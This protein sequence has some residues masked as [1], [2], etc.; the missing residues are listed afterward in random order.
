MKIIIAPDSFKENLT[1]LQ[2]A[3]A[4]EKGIKK[5][6]PDAECIKV[7]MADGGEGTVQ[8]LVDAT[9]GKI[10][11]QNVRDPLGRVVSARYGILGDNKTA[12][13]EMAEASGLPLVEKSSRNPLNTTTYGTGQLII[14]ALDKGAEK[15][16]IGLGG[17]ATVDGGSGLAQALGIKFKLKNNQTVTGYC[18]GGMLHEIDAIDMSEIDERIKRTKFIV[19]CDVDNPL[20]GNRGA[21]RV[22]GPQKG[23]T[24]EMVERLDQNLKHFADVIK[25]DLGVDISEL[26]GAGAAGGVGGALVAFVDAQLQRGVEIVIEMTKLKSYLKRADLVITGEGRIDFQTAFGKTPAGVAQAAKSLGVS[27]LAIGG[28]LADDAAGVFEH[29]IDGLE[30]STAREMS[31]EES[32]K[33]APKYLENAAERAIRLILIG[34]KLQKS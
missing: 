16:I 24:A 23:A 14:D 17:S 22:F 26:P 34:K 21:A 20:I 32:I 29:G 30:S 5:V 4:I 3:S 27:V 18:A 15:I 13:I 8:S 2:V 33:K 10:I 6:I 7:P 19:A 9:N 12:V 11:T 25:K 28:G 31:L 1:S